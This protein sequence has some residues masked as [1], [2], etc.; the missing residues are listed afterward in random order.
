VCFY[1]R[2]HQEESIEI[3][4]LLGISTFVS[5]SAVE[6]IVARIVFEPHA[7]KMSEQERG[8]LRAKETRGILDR[9]DKDLE[10]PVARSVRPHH[11]LRRATNRSIHPEPVTNLGHI[12]KPELQ[13][14]Y[15]MCLYAYARRRVR[16]EFRQGKQR[17]KIYPASFTCGKSP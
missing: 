5:V 3:K 4:I 13:Q 12:S 10:G 1:L 15:P 7:M 11:W 16:A 14:I 17:P 9:L 6:S 2:A 8:E